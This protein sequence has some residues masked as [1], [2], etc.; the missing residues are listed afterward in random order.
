MTPFREQ[1]EALLEMARELQ[2]YRASGNFMA[3]TYTKMLHSFAREARDVAVPLAEA[4]LAGLDADRA[5]LEE[6]EEVR[7]WCLVGKNPV[8]SDYHAGHNN[9]LQSVISEISRRIAA[10]RER[11]S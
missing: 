11:K 2:E 8:F 3:S 4:Y 1:V 9:T 6:L 5:R 10:I 7:E